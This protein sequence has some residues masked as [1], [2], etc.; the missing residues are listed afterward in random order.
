MKIALGQI[1]VK[2]GQPTENLAAM[3]EM[4]AQAK[5]EK[6]DLIVFPEMALSGYCLQDKW[7]DQDWCAYLES[8][9]DELLALSQ[10]IGILY[11]NLGTRPIGQAKRG[12]DGRPVRYN[13]AYFC[14]L[15]YTSRCV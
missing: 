10:G 5:A 13:A 6:A 4:I 2:Q 7:L 15:L 11:G 14:C 1:N 3:R 9:N 12:R 8:L